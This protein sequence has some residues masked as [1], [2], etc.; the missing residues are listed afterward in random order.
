MGERVGWSTLSNMIF[1]GV[2]IDILM[3]NNLV[4]KFDGF[5]P[6]IVMI[7]LGLFVLGF[8]IYLYI[9]VVL[10]SSPRDGLMITLIKKQK[11]CRF[12]KSL[13]RILGIISSLFIRWQHWHR[14]FDYGN[15]WRTFYSIGI[16]NC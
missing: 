15:L 16:L 10:G 11:T 3:L 12:Y 7:F 6:S 2:F 5:F 4:P 8:E 13:Y 14:H 9:S 1:L